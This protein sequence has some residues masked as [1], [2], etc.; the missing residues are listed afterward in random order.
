[1]YKNQINAYIK[2]HKRKKLWEALKLSRESH[3]DKK[4]SLQKA[5]REESE[6]LF[7]GILHTFGVSKLFGV[8]V[9]SSPSLS[10]TGVL[11]IQNLP[12]KAL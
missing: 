7:L 2:T 1:M 4:F 9:L 11:A 5:P 12:L 6:F 8:L 3:G 10:G